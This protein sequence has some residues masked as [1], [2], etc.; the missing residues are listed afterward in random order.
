MPL[1]DGIVLHIFIYRFQCDLDTLA[2]DRFPKQYGGTFQFWKSFLWR[3]TTASS[4]HPA[5]F[6]REPGSWLEDKRGA[7]SSSLMSH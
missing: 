6:T 2:N 4:S 5:V 1:S 3:T 7:L